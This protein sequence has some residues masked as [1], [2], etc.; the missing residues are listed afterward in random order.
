MFRRPCRWIG[1]LIVCLAT[2]ELVA[3]LDDW[4]FFDAP[5]L[6]TPDRQHDLELHAS[7]TI[8][9]KPNGAHRKWKLNADGFR[10]PA[11]DPRPVG[12]RV[13][14]LGASETFGLF[15]SEG[16]EYPALLRKH[17]A[18]IEIVNAAVAGMALPTMTNYWNVWASRYHADVVMIYPS[19]HF[20][21][22]NKPPH[23]IAPQPEI[24]EPAPPRSRFGERLV[25]TFKQASILKAIRVRLLLRRELEGK[26]DD[27]L[28]GATPPP[29]RLA[30]FEADLEKLADAIEKAGSR[31]VLITH[32]F[33]TSSPPET[34]DHAELEYFR[35]FFPRATVPSS[36]AFDTAARQV[37]ID[38]GKRRGWPVIDAAAKLTGK[39]EWFGDPVHFNDQGSE[40]MAKLLAAAVP[41]LFAEKGGR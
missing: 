32:A 9:G 35:V 18:D 8:R 40:Q 12:K 24:N 21:L 20:Y 41:A 5:I 4:L 33:K 11:I 19:P 27:Y 16:H 36:P 13:M 17:L 14:I 26:G 30:Q 37:T 34:R 22:D 10:G 6:S 31:P 15:E 29:D 39:R 25:D 23:A 38:L 7:D 3:R 28:F 2:A 1:T